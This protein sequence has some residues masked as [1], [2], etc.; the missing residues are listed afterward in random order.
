METQE[1]VGEVSRTALGA[2]KNMCELNSTNGLL[3]SDKIP[4][5]ERITNYKVQKKR[6]EKQAKKIIKNEKVSLFTEE[7]MSTILHRDEISSL[8]ERD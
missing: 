1:K 6:Q 7:D 5:Y 8:E 3:H 2:L 4:K